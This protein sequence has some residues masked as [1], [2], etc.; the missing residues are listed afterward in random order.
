MGIWAGDRG[1]WRLEVK[2]LWGHEGVLFI[3]PL[4]ALGASSLPPHIIAA[5]GEEAAY[6]RGKGIEQTRKPAAPI[7]H[8]Q[9]MKKGGGVFLL[10]IRL[11]RDVIVRR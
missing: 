11:G 2:S 8:V 10:F 5:D 1:V 4:G 3:G 9:R 6:Q 7:A